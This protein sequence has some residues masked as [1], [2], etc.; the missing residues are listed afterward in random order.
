MA[1]LRNEN[2]P[3]TGII[4]AFPT[5]IYQG[6]YYDYKKFNPILEKRLYKIKNEDT[7]TNELSKTHYGLG[8]TSY[9]ACNGNYTSKY[10]L[11]NLDIFDP[12]KEFI[13]QS[14]LDYNKFVGFDPINM[15]TT[16]LG[17]VWGNINGKYSYHEQHIHPNS[18][19]SGVYYVN[20]P[21]GS[22]NIN[23][24]DPRNSIRS[25]EME[26]N[27]DKDLTDP[28]RRSIEVEPQDGMLLLFPSWLGHEVQQNL[29]ENDRVSIAFNL[30][31]DYIKIANR[32]KNGSI[33]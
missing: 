12:L 19:L 14:I 8:W 15:E 11:E 17:V 28:L 30:I 25:V 7:T 18:F 29:T 3:N 5:C 13:W 2:L 33:E 31:P 24:I 27:R 4:L 26:P 1:F 9:H 16:R 10:N 21:K 23:F 32:A 20:A 6:Q 22:G